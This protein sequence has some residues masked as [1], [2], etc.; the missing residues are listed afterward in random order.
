MAKK[1]RDPSDFSDP[2]GALE[3]WGDSL[4]QGLVYDAYGVQTNFIAVVLNRPYPIS[5]TPARIRKF[6][7]NQTTGSAKAYTPNDTYT[8]RFKFKGRIVHNSSPHNYLPDPCNATYAKNTAR[9][10]EI[11]SMHTEF[12]SPND[13]TGN[14]PKIGDFVN[15][16]LKANVFSYDL[17]QGE[18]MSIASVGATTNP[19]AGAECSVTL[20]ELFKE[21]AD[22]GD[23]ALLASLNLPSADAS[24]PKNLMAP[25]TVLKIEAG[26]TL[27]TTFPTSAG[28]L[29]S[30]Y[31]RSRRLRNPDGSLGPAK[32][33]E[34]A[35][36]S[37]SAGTALYAA[38]AGTVTIKTGCLADN[39]C[40]TNEDHKTGPDK[41]KRCQCG[42]QCGNK[43]KIKLDVKSEDGD[44]IYVIYCHMKAVDVKNGAKVKKG[45]KVGTVGSSGYS[46]GPHLHVELHSGTVGS[47]TKK[48]DPNAFFKEYEKKAASP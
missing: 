27:E 18:F 32:Y 33:H 10:L 34:G 12:I 7:K 13:Y 21:K 29:T 11:I 35:D 30:A 45:Q 19:H 38:A 17:Q 14:P 9:A 46:S 15:V 43:V 28:V 22:L 37:A 25:G 44:S 41:N 24:R 39:K 40:L 26:K 42:S 2:A 48:W 3:L 1:F 5:V 8:P 23:P 31:G 6:F 47:Q 16:E 36:E 20:N 4:R